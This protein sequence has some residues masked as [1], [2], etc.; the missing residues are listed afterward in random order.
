VCPCASSATV[1]EA[2]MLVRVFVLYHD[3]MHARSSG[4]EGRG[5]LFH[6]FGCCS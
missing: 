2:L 3:Y 4:F 1:L 5:A 6:C